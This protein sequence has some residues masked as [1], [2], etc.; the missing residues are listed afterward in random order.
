[1]TSVTKLNVVYLSEMRT[2]C[3]LLCTV[4][5]EQNTRMNWEM[6]LKSV[7]CRH[8]GFHCL[9]MYHNF[10]GLSI[11]PCWNKKSGVRLYL[12][13]SWQNDLVVYIF[14]SSSFTGMLYGIVFWKFFHRDLSFTCFCYFHFFFFF[15][16]FLIS[17][18]GKE[19]YWFWG[20][21]TK[22]GLGPWKWI[23]SLKKS[24]MKSSHVGLAS[25][26]L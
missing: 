18:V 26:K 22:T 9:S 2:A 14:F 21:I 20:N 3:V 15:V 16:I 12:S 10:L 7:D 11:S 1:M 25:C 24:Q 17:C 19:V 5:L 6:P 23:V 8:V 4:T 13:S